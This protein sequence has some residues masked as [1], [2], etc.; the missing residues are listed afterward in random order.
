MQ[1]TCGRYL[2]C[3]IV[4]MW[5]GDTIGI[6]HVAAGGVSGHRSSGGY[7]SSGGCRSR[8]TITDCWL[9]LRISLNERFC[10]PFNYSRNVLLSER[11][12]L[13]SSSLRC[14]VLRFGGAPL[15]LLL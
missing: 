7:S 6:R 8:T 5:S 1:L 13:S 3:D 12:N 14:D 10:D 4:G 2:N 11:R 15:Q 9:S